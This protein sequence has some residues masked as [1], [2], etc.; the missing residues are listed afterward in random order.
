MTPDDVR[1][2]LAVAPKATGRE[3]DYSRP[4]WGHNCVFDSRDGGLTIHGHLFAGAPRQ[5][6]LGDWLIL[7][8]G[9]KTTRYRI[10]DLRWMGDPDDMWKFSATFDPRMRTEPAE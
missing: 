4:T 1:A 2:A 6:K 9:S 8:N 3:H 10:T 5:P 7:A